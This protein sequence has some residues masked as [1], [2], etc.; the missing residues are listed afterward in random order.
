MK[1]VQFMVSV[2]RYVF[3]LVGGRIAP[4]A[5][6]SPLSCVQY[7]DISEPQLFGSGWVKIKTHYGGICG[8]DLNNIRL[9]DS[10]S[11]SP[12]G[13]KVFTFG[14][15]QVGTIVEKGER[16]TDFHFGQRVTADPVLPCLTR[17]INPSCPNCQKGEWSRCENFAEGNLSPGLII[18]SCANTNGSWSPYF[19]AHHFQLFAI[20]DEVSDENAILVDSFCSALHPVM[21]N[22]PR[23]EDTVLV[24]GAGVVGICAVA[25]LRMLGSRA[26]IIV[27]AKHRF[28]GEWAQRYGANEIVYISGGDYYKEIAKLTGA[29]LYKPILGKRVMRG[30][31]DI[32]YECV[33]SDNSIDDALRF[34]RAGG[35]LSLVGLVGQTKKVDWTPVWFKEL[36]IRGS[37]ASC[38]NEVYQ[39][40]K[41]RPYQLALEWMAQGKLD[42]SSLLTHTFALED[43]KLALNKAM[44]KG[45]YHLVKAA[46]I[47]D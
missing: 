21:R 19:L 16:V 1:A 3:G 34:T 12:F 9:H 31:A 32:V 26:R 40:Q 13:S 7:R 11:L 47:F 27:L 28:Q 41:K 8:S 5:F 38:S 43:Y 42:L 29:T 44:H 17:G 35:T 45:R 14:H 22:F 39:G 10:P 36:N 30:G 2:P 24:I 25:A 33:G 6:I 18:G 46:F 23:D 15:E 37:L 4:G 20:P